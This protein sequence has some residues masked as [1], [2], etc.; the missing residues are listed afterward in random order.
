LLVPSSFYSSSVQVERAGCEPR[1]QRQEGILMHLRRH[2]SLAT[3][4]AVAALTTACTGDPAV[5][6]QQYLESGDRYFDQGRFAEAIIEYRNAV[7]IDP[8][9]GQARK[10][11]AESYAR[12]GDDGR[13]FEEFV[14]AADMLPADVGVQLNAGKM[15]LVARKPEEA[16]A[17][18]EAALKVQ[19]E[20][21]E[22]L[23]LRGNALSGLRTFEEALKAIE[24][25]IQLDPDRGATYTDLANIELA[26]GRRAQAE[27]AFLRATELSPNDARSHLGLG[28][29]YSSL[30]RT[31][32]AERAFVQAWKLEPEN[33]L[34]NRFLA[35][36]LFA[37]GRRAEAEPY[38]RRIADGSRGLDGALAL[39]DYYLLMRRPKEAI[40]YLENLES[41]RAVPDVTLRLARAYA[42]LGDRAKAHSLVD[43]VLAANAKLGAAHLAKGQLLLQDG[44]RDDAFAAIRTAT[45][46]DPASA[47]AQFALGRLYAARDD[48]A[49]AQAAFR[50]VLRINPR[51]TSAQVRLAALQAQSQ[52]NEAVRT[53]DEAARNE[54]TSLAARLALIRG[55]IGAKDL[56]RAEREMMKLRAEFPNAAA[57]HS[58]DAMLAMLRKDMAGAR[59]ALDRAEKLDP[60]S[61]ETL[62]AAIAYELTNNNSAAARSRLEA[63]LQQGSDPDLLLLA[64]RTYL[65]MK[66]AAAAEKALR[67]AIEADPSRNQPYA[68]LG[69]MYMD[70]KRLDEALREYE[71][72]SKRQARPIAPLTMTGLILEQQGKPDE[73]IKRYEDALAVDAQASVAANN[74]AWILAERGQDLNRALQ[75]AQTAAAA[76]PDTPE[77]IDTLGWVYYKR[78]LPQLA[79][80]LFEQASKKAPAVPE[81]HYHLG[82][83]LLKSGDKV[84]GRASLQ[85]ALTLKPNASVAAQIRRALESEKEN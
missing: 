61:L 78:D 6:K 24:Q 38:L 84:K 77:I 64:A 68:M 19:P 71:A 27:A 26:Q 12:S 42:A 67:M 81:Y 39:A 7:H 55:L 17:R 62:A 72:L 40:D 41:G 2:V 45:A 14:R 9:F 30:G 28:I 85:H 75:L 59:A 65:M 13:A 33:V 16:L 79:I 25:A 63:R 35:A 21:V 34:T 31:A 50:E 22:A 46:L 5:K 47:D 80:P 70:Q 8:M 48:R 11:L 29:F 52:P 18:A 49:A 36:T 73:A 54:P 83:A 60:A 4:L 3:L 43:Q 76:T 56:S 57:V 23:I 69:S 10:Q 20:N 82:L 51:A 66:D 58:Q 74:L 37:T 15:L 32:D 44:Q 53:A 1:L